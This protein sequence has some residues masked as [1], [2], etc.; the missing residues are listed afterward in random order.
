M[1]LEVSQPDESSLT[2]IA[3]VWFGN[4]GCMGPSMKVKIPFRVELLP[5]DNTTELLYRRMLPHVSSQG[6]LEENK[7]TN[8]A[9]NIFCFGHFLWW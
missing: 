4:T 7:V 6:R 2:L 9:L 8:W 5:A 3:L 1:S